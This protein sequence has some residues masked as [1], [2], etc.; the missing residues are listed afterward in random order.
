MGLIPM[1]MG[2]CG[3]DGSEMM[4]E[5]GDLVGVGRFDPI[6]GFLAV[7]RFVPVGLIPSWAFCE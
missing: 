3:S 2:V 7:F 4:R 6:F 1:G 5:S